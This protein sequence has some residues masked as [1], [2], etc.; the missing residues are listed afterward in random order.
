MK[1]TTVRRH[2]LSVSQYL[3]I[4]REQDGKCPLCG[5]FLETA[6]LGVKPQ[7][8]IVNG[9]VVQAAQ[10]DHDH[11]CCAGPNGCYK[12]VRG[13]LCGHCNT[14]VMAYFDKY[15]CSFGWWAYADR[16]A[17]KSIAKACTDDG[18][19]EMYYT[20]YDLPQSAQTITNA[21]LAYLVRHKRRQGRLREPV[22]PSV[23][24]PSAPKGRYVQVALIGATRTAQR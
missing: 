1:E 7:I 22:A 24:V 13:I 6:A 15:G 17:R 16:W 4:L 20:C 5:F 11:A 18:N 2:G 21:V 19:G 8:T 12:C 14:R 9:V 3:A 10:I 23:P